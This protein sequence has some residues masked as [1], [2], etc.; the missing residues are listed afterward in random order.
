MISVF[1]SAI[2]ANLHRL[3]LVGTRHIGKQ[4]CG[5]GMFIPDPKSEFFSSRIQGKKKI[6]DPDKFEVF[7]TKKLFLSSRKND[8]GCSC[9][10]QDSNF[11]PIPDPGTKKHRIPILSRPHLKSVL[12]IWDVYPGSRIRLFSIPDPGSPRIRTVSIPDPGSSSKNFNIL[13]PKKAKKMV[14]KL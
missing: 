7:L 14:S 2:R 11:S 6:P 3:F 5:S 12:R 9:R 1:H 8:L 13:T 4:F 10:I